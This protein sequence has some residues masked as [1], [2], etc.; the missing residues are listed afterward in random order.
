MTCAI[1]PK[2][3]VLTDNPACA[4]VQPLYRQLKVLLQGNDAA[5]S[6]FQ[7]LQDQYQGPGKLHPLHVRIL[8]THMPLVNSCRRMGDIQS[9]VRNLTQLISAMEYHHA[10]PFLETMNLY[11]HLAQLYID[12]ASSAQPNKKLVARAQKLAKDT[13]RKYV[14]LR[15][16]C[17]GQDVAASDAVFMHDLDKATVFR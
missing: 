3:H 17:Q 8:D 5:R 7:Q 2:P 1:G 10:S 11:Q 4:V 16:I 14:G 12:L 9:A 6:L 15:K 13:H